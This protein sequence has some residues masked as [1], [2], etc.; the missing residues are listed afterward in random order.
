MANSQ[1]S[2]ND[3]NLKFFLEYHLDKYSSHKCYLGLIFEQGERTMIQINVP[4]HDV[5]N[6]LQTKPVIG[7]DPNSGKD[8]PEIKG[9]AESIKEYLVDR[10]SQNKS[11]ILGTLTANVDPSMITI[12]KVG[13][14]LGIIAIPSDV[15]LDLTDGQHRK[16][17]IESLTKNTDLLDG[18]FFPITV[19]LEGR[20]KQCQLDFRD[21]AKAKPIEKSLLLSF[22][23]SRGKVGIAKELIRKVSMFQSKTDLTKKSPAKNTKLIY[24]IQYV[25]TLVSCSLTNNASDELDDYDIEKYSNYL[26]ECLNHFFDECPQTHKIC[27][28]KIENLTL[29]EIKEFKQDCL[30]GVSIGMQILGHLLYF[31]MN[32]YQQAFNKTK[33]S[34]LAQL[35]WNRSNSLWH[36]NV[37]RVNSNLKDTE[38]TYISFGAAALSD[39]VQAAKIELGWL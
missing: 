34:E 16:A 30:L 1:S 31:T 29:K 13:E 23:D 17:A 15:K 32:P 6:L 2:F 8:R 24:T 7:N 18:H 37:V 22:S 11:W 39:A 14:G 21:M 12:E 10:I 27:N 38:K 4:A 3:I 9:H 33:V 35:D 5:A 28:T 26:T 19:V 20:F 36:D 25:A